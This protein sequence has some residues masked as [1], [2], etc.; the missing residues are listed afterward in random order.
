M[1]ARCNRWFWSVCRVV[2]RLRYRIQVNGAEK[3]KH[4]RGPVLVLPNHPAYIDPALLSSHLHLHRPL[5][6]LVFSA[7]FRTPLLRPLFALMRAIEVPDLSQHGQAARQQ[8]FQLIDEITRRIDNGECLI[9][10]HPTWQSRDCRCHALCFRI[11][12]APPRCECC[13]GSHSRC[14]GKQL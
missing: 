8:G 3:L 10:S 2:F 7:S 1:L 9:R 12:F 13:L 4:L 11:D 5:R 6:P 14:L